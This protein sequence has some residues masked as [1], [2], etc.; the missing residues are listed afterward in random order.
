[1]IVGCCLCN[2]RMEVPDADARSPATIT[3]YN[4]DQE[5]VRVEFMQYACADCSAGKMGWSE[6]EVPK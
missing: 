4:T 5:D 2:A 6:A 3:F 1:M